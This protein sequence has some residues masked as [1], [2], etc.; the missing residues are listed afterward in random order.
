MN[1]FQSFLKRLVLD[2]KKPCLQTKNPFSC[3]KVVLFVICG[4]DFDKA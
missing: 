1:A 2:E 3:G 4:S